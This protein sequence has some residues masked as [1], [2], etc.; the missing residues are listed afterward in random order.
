MIGGLSIGKRTERNIQVGW[1]C[2]WHI[3]QHFFHI[4]VF[5]GRHSG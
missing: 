1:I 3:F 2:R 5:Y 4:L